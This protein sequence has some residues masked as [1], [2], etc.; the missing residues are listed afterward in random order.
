MDSGLAVILGAVIALTGSSIIPWIR[1]SRA[2]VRARTERS[3]ERLHDAI[4]EL[5][6]VNAGMATAIVTSNVDRLTAAYS[7][8]QR[9]ASRMLLEVPVVDRKAISDLLGNALPAP[10]ADG[11][12]VSHTLHMTHA[13][14]EV[15]I[16][17]VSGD[18]DARKAKSQ[19][20]K[21]V[22]ELG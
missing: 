4:V 18:L 21:T 16:S 22:S 8:R 13:L 1:E 19:F 10:G 20:D 6:A 2:E 12:P 15:L 3:S 11:T 9:A 14:Q 5:L 7:E 17:W